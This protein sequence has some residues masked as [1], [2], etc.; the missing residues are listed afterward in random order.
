M[1]ARASCLCASRLVVVYQ[2]CH[3]R[4]FHLSSFVSHPCR[5]ISAAVGQTPTRLL[6]PIPREVHCMLPINPRRESRQASDLQDGR[7]LDAKTQR[8]WLGLRCARQATSTECISKNLRKFGQIR[9]SFVPVCF[10][11]HIQL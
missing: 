5:N 4:Y 3:S 6:Q 1:R 10:S 11:F 2:D 7:E 8:E 9:V